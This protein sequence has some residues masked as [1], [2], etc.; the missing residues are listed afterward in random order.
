M[1]RT[2]IKAKA[3]AVFRRGRE[4][5]VNEVR[6]LDGSLVGCRIPGGHVEFS[7]KSIDTVVREIREE[8]NEA[9]E[10]VQLLGVLE[11]TF[12]YAGEPGHEIIFLYTMDFVNKDLYKQDVIHALEPDNG[13]P[14]DLYWLDPTKRPTG[15]GFWP[16][17]LENLLK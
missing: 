10:N 16:E 11:S 14:F 13:K 9:V 5:L 12:I 3:Y 4:V 6:E 1:D 15:T 2:K 7:E 8:L 17:G